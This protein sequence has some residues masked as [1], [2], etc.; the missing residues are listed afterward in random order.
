VL[1]PR[2]A[3]LEAFGGLAASVRA[4]WT[5]ETAWID[6]WDI[7]NPARGQCGTSTLVLQDEHGGRVVRGLVHE[8]GRSAV[9]TVHYWNLVGGRHVDLTWQQFSSSAFVLRSHFVD[10]DELLVSRW[11]TDRYATLRR[12]IDVRL[13]SPP[14]ALPPTSGP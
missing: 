2:N 8:T 9:P 5:A 13:A 7:G 10:R 6:Q 12:R 11:F 3:S 14:S 4:A 1:H